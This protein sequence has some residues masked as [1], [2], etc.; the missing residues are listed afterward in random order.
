M[1]RCFR[2][3]AIVFAGLLGIWGAGNADS[4]VDGIATADPAA[5]ALQQRPPW[6][7]PVST[8][9]EQG[10]DSKRLAE[11]VE[12][13]RKGELCPRLHALLVIR[14]GYLVVEEYFNNW[15]ADQIHTLQ[16]VSKSFT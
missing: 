9:D 3:S 2:F 10:L 14:H 4:A 1:K 7:W 15:R 6:E 8:P 5:V 12:L 16:S 13:I 11:L